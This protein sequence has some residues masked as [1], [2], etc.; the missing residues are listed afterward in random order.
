M[1]FSVS[2]TILSIEYKKV[3]SEFTETSTLNNA[4]KTEANVSFQT[5]D[6]LTRYKLPCMSYRKEDTYASY[7]NEKHF[8][9]IMSE[10]I[11]LMLRCKQQKRK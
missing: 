4:I 2:D 1:F 5:L 10:L 8:T 9:T 6:F 11:V 3:E 7:K